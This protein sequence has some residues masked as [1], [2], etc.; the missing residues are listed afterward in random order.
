[1]TPGLRGDVELV[2]DSV[3][4]LQASICLLGW[5][6]GAG[7]APDLQ[8][9]MDGR[10][11][12]RLHLSFHARAEVASASGA[13][14]SARGFLLVV[15]LPDATAPR[16]GADLVLAEAGRGPLRRLASDRFGV[17]LAEALIRLPRD[18][19]FEALQALANE[20]RLAPLFESSEGGHG[21]AA[22]FAQRVPAIPALAEQQHGLH[23]FEAIAAPSGECAIAVGFAQ[24]LATG[25][26]LRAVALLPGDAGHRPVPLRIAAPFR[27]DSGLT[28]Y[29]RLPESEALPV[30]GFDVLVELRRPEG[31]TLLRTTPAM[32]PAPVFL[33]SLPAL[34]DTSGGPEGADS[35]AWLRALLEERRDVFEPVIG[36]RHRAAAL[37][38][39]PRVVVL[40]AVD[41]PFAVRLLYVAAAEI[42]RRASEVLVLGPKAS[43]AA[44]AEI[45]LQRGRIPARTGL[46]LAAAVRRGTYAR[47]VLLPIDLAA[48]AESL[49]ARG[50]DRLFAREVPGTAL[51]DLLR[52]AAVA[53]S[54]EAGDALGRLALLLDTGSGARP[55]RFRGLHAGGAAGHS[56]AEHL[57]GFWRLAAPAFAGR[58]A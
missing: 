32:H 18:A 27:R 24:P 31:V 36:G 20:P 52:L 1:M 44:A 34:G 29:G 45:F 40:N 25:T 46:D 10:A 55:V 58:A 15:E 21:L 23:R 14:P 50:L 47:A 9:L 7:A 41:D 35:L 48:L 6:R 8:L 39:A 54:L 30:P 43:A 28:V 13:A 37:A 16:A 19:G 3:Q 38:E 42:E 51:P 11:L 17:P 22:L 26:T 57:S 4:R 5:V 2:L 53:G 33:E 49:P 12:P 56:I